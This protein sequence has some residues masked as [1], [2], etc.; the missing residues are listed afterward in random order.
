MELKKYYNQK[1]HIVDNFGNEWD[2]IVD[3][4]CY[5]EDNDSGKESIIVNCNGRS[6]EFE[7][8]D[9][10]DIKIVHI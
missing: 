4:Y 8:N 6:I 3:I 5:P 1:V 10:K 7:E 9:I 2:G